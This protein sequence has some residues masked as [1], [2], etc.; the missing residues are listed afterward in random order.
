[1]LSDGHGGPLV[2]ELRRWS[3]MHW[4]TWAL[5]IWAILSI[6]PALAVLCLVLHSVVAARITEPVR[7]RTAELLAV[8]ALSPPSRA[9]GLAV[10]KARRLRSHGQSAF[11]TA[12][13][14]DHDTAASPRAS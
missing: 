14:A 7:A 8:F 4:F 3:G 6:V 11:A 13:A 10:Q 1:M 12:R 9:G 2:C 5:I